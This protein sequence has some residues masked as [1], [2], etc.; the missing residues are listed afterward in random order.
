MIAFL[1]ASSC[2]AILV[3]DPRLGSNQCLEAIRFGLLGVRF[4]YLYRFSYARSRMPFAICMQ[5]FVCSDIMA[6]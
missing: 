2:D 3:Q 5:V 1:K 6:A 4:E